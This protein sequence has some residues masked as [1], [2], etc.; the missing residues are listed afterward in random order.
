LTSANH[1]NLQTAFH[2]SNSSLALAHSS[3]PSDDIRF[4]IIDVVI[5]LPVHSE[6]IM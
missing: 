2:T 1:S 3:V 6:T 4:D 5:P